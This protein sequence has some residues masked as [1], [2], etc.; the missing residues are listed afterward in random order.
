MLN[1]IVFKWN[2]FYPKMEKSVLEH[3]WSNAHH[4]LRPKI[5]PRQQPNWIGT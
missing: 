5:E 2:P 1:T 4:V 3:I